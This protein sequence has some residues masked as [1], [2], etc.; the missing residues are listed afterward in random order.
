LQ[1]A[2]TIRDNDAP[3]APALQVGADIKQLRFSWMSVPGATTYRLFESPDGLAYIQVGADHSATVTSAKLDIA[4][5]RHDW[6]NARYRLEACNTHG[7]S[8]SPPRSTMSAMLDAIGYFKSSNPRAGAAFGYSLAMS[9]DG[10]TLAVAANFEW[11]K[12]GV[13]VFTRADG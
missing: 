5:H 7:C 6:V 8:S 9:A 11:P 4:V 3:A 13:Y 1:P 2:L 10:R 12:G